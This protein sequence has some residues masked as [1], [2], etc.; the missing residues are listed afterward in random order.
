[1]R[2]MT[3]SPARQSPWRGFWPATAL[4]AVFALFPAGAVASGTDGDNTTVRPPLAHTYS[5]VARDPKT[6]ELGVAVQSHW[7]SVG[8]LVTWAEAGVGAVATQSF[9]EPSYGPKG[10][11]LMAAGSP[12]PEALRLLLKED[13]QP[14]VRQVAMVDARGNVAAHTGKLCIPAAGHHQGEGYSVQANL[15]LDDGVWPAMARAFE[16][17]EGDLADRMLAALEAAQEAG[18]DIRG[19][20]SAAILVVRGQPTGEIWSDRVL[21]LRVED[22]PTP[23]TELRRLVKL[24]RAYR[25]MN[26]G[27]GHVAA[28]RYDEALQ[29]YAAAERL[30]PD[31]DEFIF[32]HAV[33]LATIDRVKDSLPVFRRAFLMNPSWL[34]LVPR[35]VEVGLLPDDPEATEQILEMGPSS[36]GFPQAVEAP[37]T[38]AGEP[39][40]PVRR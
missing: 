40:D 25:L 31:N 11:K 10:L 4:A 15:M 26:S 24:A 7:F 6:G 23:L 38:D 20:Q 5:I 32:W 39:P 34:L 9:V 2:R 1:M 33:A 29:A 36:G 17:H 22:H 37:A 16:T 18:G 13:A 27:D 3:T 19:R 21:D 35:L 8:S 12:A 30:F 14:D 28:E